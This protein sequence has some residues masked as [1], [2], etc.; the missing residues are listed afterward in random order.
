MPKAIRVH[1]WQESGFDGISVDDVE[2]P[3]PDAEEVLVRWQVRPVH[4]DELTALT[5]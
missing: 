3:K 1:R 4:P 2:V 5:G